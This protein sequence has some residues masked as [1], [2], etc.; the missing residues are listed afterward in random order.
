MNC[1]ILNLPPCIFCDLNEDCNILY[2]YK[3][4]KAIEH[5]S[6]EL[7]TFFISYIGLPMF[8]KYMEIVCN[9]YFQNNHVV[10]NALSQVENLRLLDQ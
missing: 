5:N 8:A 7:E 2:F 1:A 3:N 4:I 10:L 9:T 6:I